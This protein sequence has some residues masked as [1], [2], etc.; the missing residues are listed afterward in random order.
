MKPLLLLLL[1]AFLAVC[2]SSAFASA[3]DDD[4]K[5]CKAVDAKTGSVYDLTPLIRTTGKDYVIDK[6]HTYYL[7]ICHKLLNNQAAEIR[8]KCGE[9]YVCQKDDRGKY[10]DAGD[11]IQQLIVNNPGS[12]TLVYTGGD[13]CTSTQKYRQTRIEFYCDEKE[14][15]GFPTFLKETECTYLFSWK[16]KYACAATATSPAPPVEPPKDCYVD[17]TYESL[18]YDLTPLYK[19][20]GSWIVKDDQ[21]EYLI[22]ICGDLNNGVHSK[23]ANNHYGGCQTKPDDPEFGKPLGLSSARPDLSGGNLVLTMTNGSLC[24]NGEF[25]RELTIIFTCA[26]G[27]SLGNPIF[28]YEE[29]DCEYIFEWQTS[30]A[31][32]EPIDPVCKVVDEVTGVVT[33]FTKFDN[34]DWVAKKD[35][36]Q[37][38]DYQYLVSVCGNLHGEHPCHS[39]AAICEIDP[40]N[41]TVGR[42]LGSRA[43]AEHMVNKDVVVSYIDGDACI[44]SNVRAST[45]IY[46][47]CDPSAGEGEPHL[48]KAEKNCQYMFMWRSSRA[49]PGKP[50]LSGGAIFGIILLVLLGL[51]FVY[52]IVG[53]GYNRTVKKA[54][55]MDQIPH[56]DLC[57]AAYYTITEYCSRSPRGLQI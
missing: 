47:I 57:Q 26:K 45:D 15:I 28:L 46:F 2:V 18:R 56:Y 51:I 27:N 36:N 38:K 22:N 9:S 19:S 21:Y 37:E 12:L 3:A 39:D 7:N 11:V 4:S 16:T 48:V 25:Q 10:H 33:D 40:D 32:G 43:T 1:S 17:N 44:G 42:A 29:G 30:V 23:C 24:H 14:G 34:I 55:G 53:I 5:Y 31:C 54:K 20:A 52:L 35:I 49:C 6:E 8:E 13:L 50:G 41:P